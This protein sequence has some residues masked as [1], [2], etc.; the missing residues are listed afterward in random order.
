MRILLVVLVLALAGLLAVDL[1]PAATSPAA[2]P[3]RNAPRLARSRLLRPSTWRS[4]AT[5]G[6]SAWNAP[7]RAVRERSRSRFVS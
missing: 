2:V 3:V 6:S 5:A 4:C 7:F 1:E